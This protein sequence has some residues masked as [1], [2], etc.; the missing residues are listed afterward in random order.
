LVAF[1]NSFLKSRVL[2]TSLNFNGMFLYAW[3]ACY[4]MKTGS[5]RKPITELLS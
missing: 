2:S 5:L 3:R 4:R 1:Q